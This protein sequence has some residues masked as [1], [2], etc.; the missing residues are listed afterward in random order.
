MIGRMWH[1][2]VVIGDM[3]YNVGDTSPLSMEIFEKT[4]TAN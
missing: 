4:G 3:L 2:V 1:Q